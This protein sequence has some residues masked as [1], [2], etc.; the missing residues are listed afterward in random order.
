[1][2]KGFLKILISNISKITPPVKGEV[3]K[4]IENFKK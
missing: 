3:K 1:M 2:E 4:Y